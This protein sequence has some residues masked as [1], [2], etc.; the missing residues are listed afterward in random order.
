MRGGSFV[1]F[2]FFAAC[3]VSTATGSSIGT[4][5]IAFPIFYPA[6]I[7]M[8]ANEMMLAGSIVSGAIFGDNLAPVSDTT[9]A[10]AS[11]QQFKDGKPADIGGVVTSRI[12]YS[13]VA[14][15]IT[16]AIFAAFGG[17]RRRLQRRIHRRGGQSGFPG[18][19]GSG[20]ADAGG[21]HK[22]EKYL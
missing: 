5:F 4:M 16:L 10:S 13:L 21:F 7:L 11:T 17:C 20:G 3:V 22:D 15:V 19:A 14:G 2:T 6:G 8:G 9:I 18:D 12:R 1:A